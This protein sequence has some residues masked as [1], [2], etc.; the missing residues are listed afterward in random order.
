MFLKSLMRLDFTQD[1]R[2]YLEFSRL[3]GNPRQAKM[4]VYFLKGQMRI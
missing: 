1:S 3:W 2:N 4:D